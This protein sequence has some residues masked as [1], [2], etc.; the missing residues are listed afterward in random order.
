MK[1]ASLEYYLSLNYPYELT[2]D[3]EEGGY[4]A[5]H[6]DLDGC[7]AQGETA[8]EAVAQLDEAR[9]L[10]IETRLEDGL[11]VPEPAPEEPSGRVSL[12]M[13]SSLH[14]KLIRIADRQGVSLNLILNSILAEYVGGVGAETVLRDAVRE[15]VDTASGDRYGAAARTFYVNE[16]SDRD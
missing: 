11:A 6:P 4:F 5:T 3:P 16:I 14:A 15:L 9:E 10:W 2:R 1:N 8:E 7:A 13:P 12:R